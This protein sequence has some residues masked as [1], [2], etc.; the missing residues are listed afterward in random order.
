MATKAKATS[1]ERDLVDDG[2]LVASGYNG[3]GR[4]DNYDVSVYRLSDEGR[5]YAP[6]GVEYIAH[7]TPV[8]GGEDWYAWGEEDGGDH[9]V[10]EL[11]FAP[12]SAVGWEEEA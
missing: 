11:L 5:S 10:A 3:G 7:Y 4:G 6:G 1:W 8:G 9:S 12:P 2:E